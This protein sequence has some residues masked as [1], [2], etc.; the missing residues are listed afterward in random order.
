MSGWT[1]FWAG[2]RWL[3]AAVLVALG[4]AFSLAAR[5]VRWNADMLAFFSGQSR[6]VADMRAAAVKGGSA[7]GEL[8]LD[9]H[10]VSGQRSVASGQGVAAAA[11]AL[12]ER[13]RRTGEFR[14]V[15]AGVGMAEMA[16]AYEKLLTQGSVFLSE[17]EQ[18]AVEK[19]AN[20]EYLAERFAAVRQRL[21][22]PDG[23][24]LLRRLA[25]DPLNVS[26]VI[27]GK[28]AALAPGGAGG[29]AGMEDG[30]LTARDA[31]GGRHVM[32]VAVPKAAAS[33]QAAVERMM[34]D[35]G[36]VLASLKKE[37]P[38]TAVW[39]VGAHRA[40]AENAAAVRRD[41][42][43]VSAVGTVA[44]ALAI[45]GFFMRQ[46]GTGWR[47]WRG[48]AGAVLVCMLPPSVGTGLALGTAGAL[49]LELPL[50]VLGFAGLLCGSTTDYGI[51]IL[52]ACRGLAR[53]AGRWD[54]EIPAHAARGMLGPVSLS[55][56][57]SVTGFAALGLSAAPGLRALGLFVAGTT[58]GIWLVTFLV[59]PAWLG[60]WIVHDEMPMTSDEAN[61]KFE[62]RSLNGGLRTTDKRR[63]TK[64]AVWA[65]GWV[66]FIGVTA[67]LGRSAMG[68]R[69][70]QDPRALD[71]SSAQL[72]ADEAA[73][74][75]VWGDLRHRAVVQVRGRDADETLTRLQQVQAYL[76]DQKR[77]GL[78]G[79]ILSPAALLPEQAVAE[80]RAAAWQAY[81]TLERR[82]ALR[83]LLEAAAAGANGLRE[84][85]FAAFAERLGDAVPIAPADQR[86]AQS[87]VAL[88]PGLVQRGPE[89]T[90]VSLVVEMPSDKSLQMATAWADELRMR[91]QEAISPTGAGAAGGLSIL[92]G[93]VLI[94]DA[95]ERARAEGEQ[96]TPLCWLVILL[97]LG[98]FFRGLRRAWLVMLCLVV[99]LVWV[100]G[101]AAMVGGGLNLLSLVP[102][103]FTLGVAVDYGI[104]RAS[105][106]TVD[107]SEKSE[108]GSQ[109][110]EDRG[111][112]T[113][114]CALTTVLGSGALVVAGHPAM[115]WLGMTLVA[116]IAG[117]YLTSLFVVGP[118]AAWM[119]RVKS[120][121]RDP[122]SERV[123]GK[124]MWGGRNIVRVGLAI[125]TLGLV[126][127]VWTRW[128]MEREIPAGVTPAAP[129]PRE[130]LTVDVES[131]TYR[132]G[133]SWMR[134]RAA[135]GGGDS[136]VWEILLAGD[137][138]ARGE[139]VA[140]LGG[141]IEL[142][143]EN[144]MF[145]QLDGFLPDVWS[146]WL[147][148]RGMEVNLTSLPSYVKPEYQ[149]EIYWAARDWGDPHAYL[150]PTYPRI[151]AYHALHDVSQ[152]LID[153]PL[154]A[155]SSFA[156]TGVVS[157]PAYSSAD[158]TGHLLLG[159]VF[160][161][162]GGESFGRQKSIT[163]VIPTEGIPF[164]HVAWPGLSGVVT[165]M[166]KEKIAVF[167]NAAATSDLRRIGTPTILM[168]R[169]VLQHARSLDEAEKIIRRT[170]VFVSDLVV[171]ADGKTG[172]TRV[173]EK[174][175]AR[176]GVYDVAASAVV[177]NHL[178]TPIFAH[179][180]SNRQRMAEGTTVQRYARARQLL[181]RLEHRVTPAALAGLLRDKKGLDDKALGYGNRNAIDG[182]IACHTVIMDVTTGHMWVAA[183]PN[184]EGPFL[185]VDVLAM[186]ERTAA[187][188]G[189]LP[190]GEP[191]GLAPLGEDAIMSAD[192]AWPH[193]VA[194][195]QAAEQAATALA[196]GY[197]SDARQSADKVIQANPE[198][199][200][201]YELRGRACWMQG[202]Y[203][204]AKT[205][206]Q[207]ALARDP[208]YLPR[209][210]SLEG[211]LKA[212]DTHM[213]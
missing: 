157:L 129:R 101:V 69:F 46:G 35:V 121:T 210:E 4:V 202:D 169:D 31:Q 68:V 140:R 168:A 102:V 100:L 145:E 14:E 138:R 62:I 9:V 184:A 131:R 159:R 80:K 139:A 39:V 26:E 51:Q 146:R 41:V 43:V 111:W 212:C 148:V 13:L 99:G 142:R 87:P 67:L 12:A 133:P 88:F 162:E 123:V 190:P 187:A 81:W 37:F 203:A 27:A 33:D 167:L 94:F 125:L 192:G 196:A 174:S 151:L 147:V 185:P 204:A 165:G 144:E 173:F 65:L 49:R 128:R 60:P 191:Q 48:G 178:T 207:Q 74:Y 25:A 107:S 10:L 211:L 90:A 73:F 156:C 70:N 115:R 2:H 136:G 161:F 63:K 17:E 83:Q 194:A 155:T 21:A 124:L 152:M 18:A 198:F 118:V 1:R 91:F 11:Q 44:V 19:R 201:G 54:R 97:P 34:R 120:E 75:S 84:D 82:A 137:A 195:R 55:V 106:K 22:D 28:L 85:A 149:Q 186:L 98:V 122:K 188:P 50:I 130:A 24:I 47:K 57:T 78:V 127:P 104:Y 92:S 177:T 150:A 180:S 132:V 213:Q 61:P 181:D 105:E 109:E 5:G 166:N 126:L 76:D 29:A 96:L 38:A 209:R 40:Y 32:L 158:G 30:L 193:V 163:F 53:E 189:D 154:L 20:A 143:V 172:Q 205:A 72:R 59:L 119:R 153:N 114:L 52:C 66:V 71:G 89:A 86:V 108:D 15:W 206:L 95:V 171:V 200:L 113:F 110:A 36:Q 175:P 42:G 141:P 160:D 45:F 116:G 135:A 58:V 183:W 208:P 23:E 56:V 112:A 182:L 77:D 16:G 103:L 117:G 93:K 197:Y 170:Q 6:D 134:W 179:D 164:A 199:Y 64:G 176:I 79:G 8:R 3:L 7:G